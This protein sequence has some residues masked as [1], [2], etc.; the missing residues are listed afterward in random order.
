MH[1]ASS[2]CWWAENCR[3]TH[4]PAYVRLHVMRFMIAF[5]FHQR[6]SFKLFKAVY[7]FEDFT[8]VSEINGPT[9]AATFIDA[10]FHEFQYKWQR[11][12]NFLSLLQPSFEQTTFNGCLSH[13]WLVK[14]F[15]RTPIEKAFIGNKVES[16]ILPTK[17][18]GPNPSAHTPL[19]PA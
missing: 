2:A 8:I 10:T 11:L 6:F 7:K 5:D 18:S 15:V 17:F 12:W 19:M 1:G 4:N 14:Q 13:F 9:L 16:L 3:N